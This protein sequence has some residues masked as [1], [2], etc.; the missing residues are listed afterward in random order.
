MKY[1]AKVILP[2][3]QLESVSFHLACSVTKYG[4]RRVDGSFLLAALRTCLSEST[5]PIFEFNTKLTALKA[6][7][8]G[9]NA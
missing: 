1:L 9:K 8:V 3:G 5:N 2:E 4:E 6:Y 7:N